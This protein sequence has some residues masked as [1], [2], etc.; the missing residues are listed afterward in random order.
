MVTLSSIDLNPKPKAIKA[1]DLFFGQYR[2]AV[3]GHL[4]AASCL[5]RYK[6]DRGLDSDTVLRRLQHRNGRFVSKNNLPNL[7]GSWAT[8]EDADRE[9]W[10]LQ[11]L[12]DFHGLV[13]TMQ[14]NIKVTFYSD[15]VYVYSNDL[16]QIQQLTKL[17]GLSINQILET[18]VCLP[19]DCVLLES[20]QHR[21]RSFFYERRLD[22][23]QC[24]ALQNWLL[25]RTDLSCSRALREWCQRQQKSADLDWLRRYW[26]FD[27]D[28]KDLLKLMD[29]VLPG[30]IRDTLPIQAK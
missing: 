25:S 19:K 29:F 5:R 1:K 11:N 16:Q 26:Y 27:H 3:H 8:A 9:R 28:H 7:G 21:Y 2:W 24:R 6:T 12:M 22:G 20:P 23:Y 14:P 18:D 13:T 30:A 17:P 4:R 15:W 10:T